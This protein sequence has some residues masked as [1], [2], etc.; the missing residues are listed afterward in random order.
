MRNII[1][2]DVHGCCRALGSLMYRIGPDREKDR[3]IFLGDL[4]D[5]G[6]ESWEVFECV[7]MLASAYG[8]RFTLLRG[9][10][11]DYL[12]AEKLTLGQK[13]VWNRVGRGATIKSFREHG[14]RMEDCRP[15]LEDHC[16]VYWEG[17]GFQCAHAGIRV[18]PI[19]A[20]DRETLIHD[21]GTVLEN[22]YAGPLTVTGHIAIAAPVW[23]AGDGKTTEVLTPGEWR[24]LPEK[25]V[26]C[27]DTGCG[28]GGKLTGMIVEDGRYML[29]QVSERPKE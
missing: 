1:I 29:E 7:K 21:H 5:R 22:K 25:G 4:F 3:L 14:G 12:M 6:P 2:G 28:K 17:E 10:H 8:T 13:M 26:I 15:W 23:F 20:N 16:A 11:E 9:N 27:I 19:G 18:D 24:P